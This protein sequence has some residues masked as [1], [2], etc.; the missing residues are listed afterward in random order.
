MNAADGSCF[1]CQTIDKHC[2][3]C[4]SEAICTACSNEYE[5]VSYDGLSC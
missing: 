4:T 1:N 3:D 5:M 2:S